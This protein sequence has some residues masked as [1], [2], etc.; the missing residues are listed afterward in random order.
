MH[1]VG[2]VASSQA[3]IIRSKA[4]AFQPDKSKAVMSTSLYSE[5]HQ[6]ADLGK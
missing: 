5:R 6:L 4:G 1:H 3:M 2:S